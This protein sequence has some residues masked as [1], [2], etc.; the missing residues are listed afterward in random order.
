M[1]KMTSLCLAL[2]LVMTMVL[3]GVVPAFAV[4]GAQA[5]AQ[6]N[7]YDRHSIGL[8]SVENARELGGYRTK[9]GRTV[10]FG[11]L[12][13]TGELT[14]LSAADQKKLVDRYHLKK[15]VDLRSDL[16]VSMNGEDVK[17]PGV[18]YSRYPFQLSPISTYLQS[19]AGLELAIDTARELAARDSHLSFTNAY[20]EGGYMS[21]YTSKD[22]LAMVRGFFDELLDANGDTVLFHCSAGKDRTGNLAMLLLE[23]L[24]V[25]RKTI[26]EDYALTN[27]YMADSLQSSYDRIYELTGS[28]AIAKDL[29]YFNGVRRSWIR[30]SYE[31]I[32]RNY[33]SVNNYL[34]KKVGLSKKDIRK[35][36]KAYLE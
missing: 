12:L 3:V 29:S 9:D 35:L 16:D 1:K 19:T 8:T 15:V 21:I 27:V 13:R 14:D 33:G 31:T 18:E 30:R 36:Q 26:I 7:A 20:F 28:D 25:D 34:T 32:E 5:N 23:V 6:A 22:G 17:V 11:K 4:T 24:G 2:F 10:R